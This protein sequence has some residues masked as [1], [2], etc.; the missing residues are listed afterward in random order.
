MTAKQT[1]QKY[2]ALADIKI[3]GN[4]PWDIKVHNPKFYSRVLAKGSLGLGE[5]YMD[6]WWDCKALDQLF[7]KILIAELYKKVKPL[8][9]LFSVLKSKMINLQSKRRAK[10][11]SEKHYDLS[12]D[13]YMSFLDP[14]NQYTCGYFK[15]TSD[16]NKAQEQKLDMICKKLRLKKTDRVLEIGCGWGGFAKFASKKYGCHVTGISISEEQIKYAKKFCKGLPV[17]IVKSDYRDFEGKFDKILIC[18]MIEHVGY[19]NYRTIIKKVNSCLKDNGLFL[20]HTIGGNTSTTTI[21]PW[22]QKYIFQVG[23]LP[24]PQQLTKSAEN[25]FVIE[26]W[27][28]FGTPNYDQTLMAWYRNFKKN[29]NGI[30]HLYDQ[31]FYR[32]WNYYLLSCAG[33]FRSRENRLWQIVFSKNGV[34]DGYDAVR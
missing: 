2:L 31:R 5:S 24:S 15:N 16:L 6:G 34:K 9:L 23:M 7:Y 21:D 29:W 25:L 27:H 30:K 8:S 18:G 12:V 14:Y 22:I 19:K 1:V 4:R 17:K 33:A 10:E 28:S 13:L 11:V 26:D 32:M 20:L 3:N